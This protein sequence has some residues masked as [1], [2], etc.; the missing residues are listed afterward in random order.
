M[1]RKRFPGMREIA[2][3]FVA[4]LPGLLLVALIF[5]GIRAGIFTA[6]ESAAI[7]VVYAILITGLVYRKLTWHA[8]QR[9]LHGRR[10]HDWIDPVR[11]RCCSFVRLVAGL[12]AGADRPRWRRSPVADNKHVVLHPADDRCC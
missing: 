10:A 9:N 3:R 11:D 1:R 2:V 8:L 5:F 4:A 7:A 6:V 12:S